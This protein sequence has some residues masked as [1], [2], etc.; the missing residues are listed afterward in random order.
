VEVKLSGDGA[1]FHRSTSYI[2]LSFSFPSLDKKALSGS[3]I[4]LYLFK[5]VII[6]I[7]NH[8]FAVINGMERFELLEKGLKD[9][10]AEVNTLIDERVVQVND[11]I[12][13]L[14]FFLGGD[15][16]VSAHY[17]IKLNFN[18]CLHYIFF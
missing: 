11:E 18:Y 12:V 17:Q 1:P 16:K 3:G 7:G 5:S 10:I 8:T 14:D 13:E 2:L 4:C 9:T 6:I 15:Y